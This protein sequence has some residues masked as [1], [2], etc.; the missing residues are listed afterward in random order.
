M[1][2][3]YHIHTA[4]CCH[5]CGDM[6]EYLVFA[7]KKGLA[8]IGFADH[9]P[10]G[11]LGVTPE[12]PVS[13]RPDELTD[14]IE[15]VRELQAAA[16]IPVRL[17]VEMDYLPGREKETAKLLA[18]YPF[19]YVIGSIHFLD[20]WD[21]T[22][23]GHINQYNDKDIDELYDRYFSVVRQMA[24]SGLFQIAGHLDVVKKFSFFPR[25]D[26]SHVLEGTCRAL[27]AADI[28]VEIN[29]SGWR[30]PV[31]ESY[32]GEAFLATCYEMGVPV[33]LGSDA[34]RPQDVG[35]GLRRA[36]LVLYKLGYREVASFKEGKRI[37]QKLTLDEY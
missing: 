34:H 8:E 13:M 30:A 18:A 26:W 28:C 20:G 14:Y 35:S 31:G 5:A 37:M 12:K 27:K 33:T 2:L 3:D 7:Q 1:I 10:L 29:S 36:A 24:Q 15:D 32:P 17:G 16:E 22:H 23:P 19:D 9:F 6:A 11:M 21:F 4:R 25:R